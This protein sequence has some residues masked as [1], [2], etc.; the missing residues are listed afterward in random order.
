MKDYKRIVCALETWIKEIQEKP[1][2]NQKAVDWILGTYVNEIHDGS[3]IDNDEYVEW[4]FQESKDG[5]Q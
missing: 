5:M 2:T 3:Y 1:I 4:C